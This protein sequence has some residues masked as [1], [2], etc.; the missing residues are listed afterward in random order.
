MT[1]KF[2]NTLDKNLPINEFYNSFLFFILKQINSVT[3][4]EKVDGTSANLRQ[5]NNNNNKAT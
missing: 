4:K 5:N 3:F 2:Y 1:N